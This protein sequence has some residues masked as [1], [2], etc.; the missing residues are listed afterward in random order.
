[1][2]KVAKGSHV[3]A[4]SFILYKPLMSDKI[5]TAQI[6]THLLPLTTTFTL[7]AALPCTAATP[8][9]ANNKV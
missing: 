1:M 6:P 3:K 2:V 8:Y 7:A 5:P 4:T 9:I